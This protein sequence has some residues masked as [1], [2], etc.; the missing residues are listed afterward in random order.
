MIRLH[1]RKG[2]LGTDGVETFSV[3]PRAGLTPRALAFQV[4]QHLPKSVAIECA[5]D[6]RRLEDDELD[7][8]LRD[9][10]DVMLL[11]IT[12]TGAELGAL[13]IEAL[14]VAAVSAAVSY[15]IYLVSPRPKPQ[16]LGQE[17]GDQESATYA[18]DGIQTNY[19]QGFPVPWVY[20]RHA[21][22]GQVVYT[23]VYAT[24]SFTG[25]DDRLRVMLALC[26]GPIAR[27]GDL[28]A[29]ERNN[30]GSIVPPGAAL[31]TSYQS[32]PDHI[33][34]D[35]NLLVNPQDTAD[36]YNYPAGTWT[37]NSN[38]FGSPIPGWIAEF[39]EWPSWPQQSTPP[40]LIGYGYVYQLINNDFN[41]LDIVVESGRAAVVGE[42]VQVSYNGAGFD[43]DDINGFYYLAGWS[44][45]VSQ[46]EQT[47][48]VREV[49][50]A[51]LWM[52]P[53]SLEQTPLPGDTFPGTATT[54][55]P[56]VQLNATDDQF[57]YTYS[58][59]DQIASVGFV[60]SFSG[61]LYSV[62]TNGTQ[63]SFSVQF[64][65]VWRPQGT[66]AWRSFYDPNN[67]T[68]TT[69]LRT[70]TANSLRV[71]VDSWTGVLAAPNAPAVTGPIE[72]KL[73]RKTGA[74]GVGTSS[75]AFWR[76]VVVTTPHRLAYPRTALLGF[77]LG[78]GARFSGGLPEFNVR[79]DG[80]KV[81]VWDATNGWSSPTWDVPAAAPFN[82]M[83]HPPGRNPAWILLDF[84]LA[85]WGLGRWLG[86]ADIDL[87][88]FRR[89]AAFCDSDPSP[90][91]PWGEPAFCCDLVG[92]APRP[93][94]EWVLAI[95]AAGR[96]APVYR[97]GKISVSYQYR[98][99]HSDAGVSVPAKSAV[100]L[101]SSSQVEN[102]QVTWLPK[103]NRPTAFLFQY[104][105]E[106]QLY[107]QDVFPVEDFESALNDPANLQPEDYRP[108][109]IQA[110]GV[111]RPSQIFRE[112]IFR[113][114][115]QRLVRRELTFRTG[116]WALAAEIGDL[117]L[118][119]HETLRPFGSDVPSAVTVYKSAVATNQIE[120]DHVIVGA[121]QV[122]VR[123]SNGVAQTRA[124]T[125]I[126]TSGGVSRLTVSGAPV[127]I[128]RGAAAVVGLTDKLVE[129]YEVVSITL[130]A[131]LK[132][133]VKCIQWVPAIHD[134]VTPAQ[135]AAE[136][137]DGTET[138]PAGLLR[139]PAQEDEPEVADLQIIAQRDASYLIA[140]SKPPAR[141]SSNVRV[142]V[143]DSER[144][145][146]EIL[147]E[148][149]ALQLVWA[150]ASAGRTYTISAVLEQVSGSYRQ[151]ESG[152]LRTLTVEE[153]APA[154]HPACSNATATDAGD[155][156]AVT[157]DDLAMRDVEGYELRVGSCWAAGRTV[158]AGRQPS[159]RLEHA[160][161]GGSLMLAAHTTG[162]LYGQIA[163]L[164]TPA[165]RPYGTAQIYALDDLA[166]T[167]AG[168][169]VGTAYASGEIA[170]T[171]GTLDGT[172]TGPEVLLGF[173]ASAYWQVS[174]E[175]K[176]I[177][178]LTVDALA[179]AI[180]SGEALWRTLDGRP[181]S[182]LFP[183]ID[184][185]TTVD[186]LAQ[187]IDDLPSSFLVHGNVGEPGSHT[188]VE[189]ESRY[190]VGSTWSSWAPHVDQYRVASR[191]QARVRILR[192][193]IGYTAAVSRLR[194]AV[195]I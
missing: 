117:I 72:I 141:A 38:T 178:L 44:K 109:T 14:I 134:P 129:T 65:Y 186:D 70:I 82:F 133:E 35:G 169:H 187:P 87:P 81:R 99:A 9:G 62:A 160:P 150:T 124:I 155:H 156:I 107:A 21:V 23:D 67:P 184:W 34:V 96:A 146:W 41:N 193:D 128:T 68:Q 7:V 165:W 121:T 92:D 172:Y 37:N 115:V 88:A 25:L 39:Y 20:G 17:R 137:V 119:E 174:C 112:G 49:P 18:W 122:V 177:E 46:Y 152:S 33:R 180:G 123:D 93:A 173:Q 53:G 85:P 143:R 167:P 22:G 54:F 108:E 101:L 59:T 125:G 19:G 145:T 48:R 28:E 69:N 163:T 189:L 10:C 113:H 56:N 154:W 73:Q 132:R 45:R 140:W 42:F 102:V 55:T 51:R 149:G 71:L 162:G 8:D 40:V 50:G 100:Q 98:D 75:G 84:L 74:G 151:P 194:Y 185:Q 63:Q 86:E 36:V 183:G 61:G 158:Y 164:S 79:V 76:N 116:P 11:P 114:R 135:Y 148:T 2:L 103:A 111:T 47:V 138:A 91:S 58:A 52:R 118:F 182:S 181:A 175:A 144:G 171:S 188:R 80:A 157:W 192:E 153:F 131:D 106:T 77:E 126:V 12:S 176:E 57:T 159:A 90:A 13:I 29:I 195:N 166:T 142:Y 97:N 32:L 190:Y 168:T 26:E 24:Q 16:G 78:A 43:F 136:G 83:Q 191:M 66:E 15:I 147:G 127:T 95:C 1:V 94:W 89:W 170:L 110:Y 64:E 139:Q 130:Q 30:L 27:I 31:P 60:V 104:L 6:G 105:N 3:E 5:V 161:F 4:E 179:F 120:V